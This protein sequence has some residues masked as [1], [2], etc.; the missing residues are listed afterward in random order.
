MTSQNA[1]L[2]QIIADAGKNKLCY[3]AEECW[4]ELYEMFDH[5]SATVSLSDDVRITCFPREVVEFFIFTDTIKSL[6]ENDDIFDGSMKRKVSQLKQFDA[7]ELTRIEQKYEDDE[8]ILKSPCV[9]FVDTQDGLQA[10][11]LKPSSV[12]KQIYS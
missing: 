8:E 7:S 3:Q 2:E 6:S 12:L 4:Q 5:L 11:N 9:V 1:V 10:Y